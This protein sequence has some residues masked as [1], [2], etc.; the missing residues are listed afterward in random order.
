MANLTVDEGCES[1]YSS[2]CDDYS[3]DELQWNYE[4]GLYICI[5]STKLYAT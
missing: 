3:E 1:D 2:E 4:Q 5:I